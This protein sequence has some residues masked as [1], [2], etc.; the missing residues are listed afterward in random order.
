MVLAVATH[1]LSHGAGAVAWARLIRASAARAHHV[2]TWGIV[3][4]TGAGT[5]VNAVLPARMGDPVKVW[6]ARRAAPGVPYA[7]VAAAL[8]TVVSADL[9]IGLGL[10]AV[11]GPLGLGTSVAML[12]E[13]DLGA[14]GLAIAVASAI[15]VV[16]L[17]ALLARRSGR[18]A[19]TA[20]QLRAGLEPLESVPWYVR[21]ILSLQAGGW[22]LRTATAALVLVAAGIPLRPLTVGVVVV[23]QAAASAVPF[24]PGGFL[25]KLGIFLVAFAELAEAPTILAFAV[26]FELTLY[27]TNALIGIAALA[28]LFRGTGWTDMW[29][30]MRA[31][32]E[33]RPG[34]R[35]PEGVGAGGARDR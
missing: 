32:A 20:R 17:L 33:R 21:R 28:L 31:V 15:G 11:G 10:I 29:H 26:L 22:L 4:A 12:L 1:A 5:A 30:R 2:S 8:L 34:A 7:T 16:I 24:Q 14:T 25:L 9:L 3:L 6:A 23:A 19:L 18:L 27:L 35:A 13:R